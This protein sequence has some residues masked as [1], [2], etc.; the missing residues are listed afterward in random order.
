MSIYV[1]SRVAADEQREAAFGCEAVVIPLCKVC[2]THRTAWFHDCF[3]AERSLALLVSCYRGSSIGV[4][5]RNALG[6]MP[7]QRLKARRKL[8]TSL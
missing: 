8:R 3:A 6:L 7:V 2:L 5:L 1:Q 4:S